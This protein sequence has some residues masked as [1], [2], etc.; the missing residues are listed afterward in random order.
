ML[1]P[2]G[3]VAAISLKPGRQS[4]SLHCKQQTLQTPH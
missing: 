3:C 2:P 1:L 4:G